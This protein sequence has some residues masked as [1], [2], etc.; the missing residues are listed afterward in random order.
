MKDKRIYW[1]SRLV[2]VI[3]C[4]WLGYCTWSLIGALG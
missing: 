1:E 2:I 4:I 3:M